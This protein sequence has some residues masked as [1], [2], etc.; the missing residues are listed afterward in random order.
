MC[1]KESPA[2]PGG[3][4]LDD[5]RISILQSADRETPLAPRY[6]LFPIGYLRAFRAD[7]PDDVGFIWLELCV[8]AI[9]ERRVIPNRSGEQ[10]RRREH[11]ATTPL[12]STALTQATFVPPRNLDWTAS[13]VAGVVRIVKRTITAGTS[14]TLHSIG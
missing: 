12:L 14:L 6:F 4:E 8:S 5:L 10:H 13:R 3:R 1:W 9:V 11:S 7:Y 2:Q